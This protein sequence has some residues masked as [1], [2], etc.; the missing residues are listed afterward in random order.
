MNGHRVCHS[1]VKLLGGLCVSSE[2][3]LL[4]RSLSLSLAQYLR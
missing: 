3:L 4:S 2:L 1:F